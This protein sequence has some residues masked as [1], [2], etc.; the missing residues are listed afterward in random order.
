V[1]WLKPFGCDEQQLD[2][3]LRRIR[4]FTH[5][6][7][8]RRFVMLNLFAFRATQPRDMLAAPDPVGPDN[9]RWI[10][11]TCQEAAAVACGWGVHGSHQGRAGHVLEL[12][13]PVCLARA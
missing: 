13:A 2:P 4:S 12:L 3:T 9:D 8:Y 6:M 11:N 1:D 10:L 7:G 5:A